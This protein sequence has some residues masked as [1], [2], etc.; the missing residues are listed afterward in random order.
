VIPNKEAKGLIP[1][2]VEL[3]KAN[4]ERTTYLLPS[5]RADLTGI[6][7]V[8][9]HR[10]QKDFLDRL[11]A[12]GI[13]IRRQM[14]TEVLRI[15]SYIQELNPSMSVADAEIIEMA[16]RKL[17]D[18]K[19]SPRSFVKGYLLAEAAFSRLTG[20]AHVLKIDLSR[21]N[22]SFKE[23]NQSEISVREKESKIHQAIME[24]RQ[25]LQSDGTRKN[26]PIQFIHALHRPLPDAPPDKDYY[27][28]KSRFARYDDAVGKIGVRV[29]EK[30]EFE[31]LYSK[32]DADGG[33]ILLS[34]LVASPII[35]K[36]SFLESRPW[37]ASG[38]LL[39]ESKSGVTLS[40]P[41]TFS[42]FSRSDG[43]WL[44]SNIEGWEEP[45][46]EAVGRAS[47]ELQPKFDGCTDLLVSK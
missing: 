27:D 42:F 3:Y 29:L 43:D 36:H 31:K 41:F 22:R 12:Q 17:V 5:A 11:E 14:A 39:V 23:V 25:R 6:L 16:T 9:N 32:V 37:T 45:L 1:R 8:L 40:V 26:D 13:P 46:I 19:P 7:K 33:K 34:D 20:I 44:K 15:R 38:T 4:Y 47:A 2:F 24:R 21:V 18:H 28:T 30:P 35:K 10:R